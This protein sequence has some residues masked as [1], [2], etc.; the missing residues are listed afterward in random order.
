[1]SKIF[2]S[3]SSKDEIMVNKFIDFLVL[4]FGIL[5]KDILCTALKG[6]TPSG[7]IIMEKIKTDLKDSEK[8]I[9]LI[10]KNYLESITCMIELGAAWYQENKLIPILIKP[11]QYATLNNTPL[12]GIQMLML[13]SSD[14]ITALYREFSREGIATNE[15]VDFYHK[16][17]E[18]VGQ[19]QTIE[20]I[21]P[22]QQG[23]Y[24]ARIA[25]Q[26]NTPSAYR[27]YKLDGLISHPSVLSENETH[28]IFYRA[29]MYADLHEGDTIRF[30]V[31][32]T[33]LRDF[34]DLKNARNIYPQELMKV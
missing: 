31:D 26:R 14:D 25:E 29:G 5:R 9:C 33:E 1:M 15:V 20:L 12:M 19:L 34:R 3:H 23:Y 21:Q 28:W 10:T 32:K 6:T 4:G 7:E 2:I 30:A 18:Y 17:D 11:I 24:C 13:D 22:D 27:C 16:R 8:I